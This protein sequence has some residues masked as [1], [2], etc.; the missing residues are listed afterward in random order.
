[1]VL[2][3]VTMVL[4]GVGVVMVKVMME[5]LVLE[6]ATGGRNSFRSPL[7]RFWELEQSSVPAKALRAHSVPGP[8]GLSFPK[9]RARPAVSFYR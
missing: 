8:A 5:V 6:V 9:Q 7:R 4:V 1:M 2:V 3:E